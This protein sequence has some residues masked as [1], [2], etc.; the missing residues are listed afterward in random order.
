MEEELES[1]SIDTDN[2]QVAKQDFDRHVNS[3]DPSLLRELITMMVEE[4]KWWM[5]P[6]VLSILLVAVV[7]VLTQNAAAPFI[8][9]L[10]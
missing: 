4:K 7:V 5:I 3:R 10:F 2:L 1:P 6:I 8:Y 9:S